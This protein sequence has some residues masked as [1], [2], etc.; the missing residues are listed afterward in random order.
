[1]Y[2]DEMTNSQKLAIAKNLQRIQQ[3]HEAKKTVCVSE[4]NSPGKQT[5]RTLWAAF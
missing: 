3:K 1:M 2:C 5:I 4:E